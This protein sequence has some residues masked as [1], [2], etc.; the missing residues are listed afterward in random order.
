[1]SWLP[2]SNT[3]AI[4]AICPFVGYISDLFGRRNITLAGCVAICVGIILVATAKSFAP[5]IVGMVLAG[6][7]AGICELTAL[8]G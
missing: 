7:G 2:V 4:A 6:A 1:M 3:L 5:A 8:A